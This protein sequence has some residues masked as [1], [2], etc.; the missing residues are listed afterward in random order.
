M[1]RTPGTQ[2]SAPVTVLLERALPEL[3]TPAGYAALIDA[4]HLRVPLPRTLSA[5]ISDTGDMR[6]A[7][8]QS[9][10]LL[11][12][13]RE[14]RQEVRMFLYACRGIFQPIPIEAAI[15]ISVGWNGSP[16]G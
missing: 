6:V 5:T 10:K 7:V 12:A 14:R 16:T 1:R 11:H 4:F 8:T 3:G 13:L 15:S 2:F 9:Y